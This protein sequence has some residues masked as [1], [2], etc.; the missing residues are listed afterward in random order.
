MTAPIRL[1]AEG[2]GHGV[3]AEEHAAGDAMAR[4]EAGIEALR[5]RGPGPGMEELA[6]LDELLALL[7]EEG[8]KLDEE[9]TRDSAHPL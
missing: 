9:A 2:F 5:A 6:I 7:A 3:R 4:I 8:R 1:F